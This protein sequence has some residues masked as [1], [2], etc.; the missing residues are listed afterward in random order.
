MTITILPA[1]VTVA[2]DPAVLGVSTGT[3]IAK[4]Y[5][6]APPYEGP[7]SVTPSAEAQILETAGKRVGENITIQPVPSNYGL[8]T[9]TGS[10]LTV[11]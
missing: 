5:V 4:E 10:V 8:I 1:A 6:E 2:A 3:P 7:L 11:S 9:W